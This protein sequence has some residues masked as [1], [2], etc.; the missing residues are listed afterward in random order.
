M[1]N[2]SLIDSNLNISQ[3]SFIRWKMVINWTM[4]LGIEMNN[5]LHQIQNCINML[6]NIN[7]IVFGMQKI[8]Y[9]NNNTRKSNNFFLPNM[10]M[11]SIQFWRYFFLS[12]IEHTKHPIWETKQFFPI[13]DLAQGNLVAQEFYKHA[14]GMTWTTLTCFLI[15]FVIVWG[16]IHKI[17]ME[18]SWK[19]FFKILN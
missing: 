10:F 15:A 19:T 11:Q 9:P 2:N 1:Q 12:R 6:A 8:S 5:K 14:N 18:Y 13:I 7:P 3:P 17:I 4:F 16:N